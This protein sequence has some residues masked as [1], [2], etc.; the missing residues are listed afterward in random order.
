M[1]KSLGEK[2]VSLFRSWSPG[3]STQ[4]TQVGAPGRGLGGR[5]RELPSLE[6]GGGVSPQPGRCIFRM[7]KVITYRKL[8]N[9]YRMRGPGLWGV[10]LSARENREGPGERPGSWGP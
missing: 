6:W 4:A 5:R 2:Y 8:N 10:E 1:R 3:H 7:S 9:I